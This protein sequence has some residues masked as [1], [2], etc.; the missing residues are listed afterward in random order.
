MRLAIFKIDETLSGKRLD[1]ITANFLEDASRTTIKQAIENGDIRVN[2]Q[3]VKVAYK[4]KTGDT[5]TVSL[6]AEKPVDL[7]YQPVDFDIVYEDDYLMVI[8][9]PSG[10]IVHPTHTTTETTLVH[11]LL[12]HLDKTAFDDPLRPGI[13]HRLDKDTSGLLVVAKDQQTLNLLQAMLKKRTIKRTYQALVEGVIDH[14]KGTIE[15]PVGRHPKRRH[16]MSVHA[17]G[18]EST[19]HFTVLERFKDHTLVACQLETG[20]THQIRVHMQYIE[21][22]VVGDATYGFRK[23]KSDHGQ[24]LHAT[25]LAFSHPITAEPLTFSVQL[26]TIFLEKL[27]TLR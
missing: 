11:G 21:H 1:K 23:S 18:K 22:P 26:P 4:V 16:L 3:T 14:N 2:N 10:L 20:R 8:N 25:K 27:Q 9:K 7:R 5:I 19:T 13:V 24:Y 17:E 15:A 6:P 12:N